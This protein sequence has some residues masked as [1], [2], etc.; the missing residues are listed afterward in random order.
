MQFLRFQTKFWHALATAS[1]VGK[2]AQR[3]LD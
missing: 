2:S 3:Q 1:N